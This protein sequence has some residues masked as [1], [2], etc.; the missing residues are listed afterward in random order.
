LLREFLLSADNGLLIQSRD[1]GE[2]TDA[3]MS[4]LVG[5]HGGV[6][7]SLLLIQATEQQVHLLMPCPVG[8]LGSLETIRALAGMKGAFGHTDF[9]PKRVLRMDDVVPQKRNLSIYEP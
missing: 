4:N 2:E 9:L 3:A 7:A 6:P 1:L 5:F 8:M